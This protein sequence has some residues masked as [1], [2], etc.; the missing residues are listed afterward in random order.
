M[1][2]KCLTLFCLVDGQST[3][4]AFSVKI[5][6]TDS[7]DDLKDLIKVKKTVDFNDIDADKLSIW[8]VSIPD[9]DDERAILVDNVPE[10]KRK[11]LKATTKLSRVF[12]TELPEDTIHILVHRPPLAQQ[13]TPAQEQ[14]PTVKFTITINGIV[15]KTVEWTTTA[16]TASLDHLR[17]VIY[18][19]HPALRDRSH[20]LVYEVPGCLPGYLLSDSALQAHIGVSVRDGVKQLVM[21]FEDPPKPF[22]DI[23]Y[24]DPFRL[25]GTYVPAF[26]QP[27][28]DSGS[29]PLTSEKHMQAL[30][31]LYI[32]LE[33]AIA[34]MP[35]GDRDISASQYY[36]NAFLMHAV[37]LFP[38]L[39][40]K[41]GMKLAGRRAWGELDYG[42]ESEVDSSRILA[43]T[44]FTGPDDDTGVARNIVQ[45][46][47]ISSNRKRKR[48]NDDDVDD[49]APVVSYG[50]ATNSRDWFLQQCSID[51][52]QEIGYNFPTIQSSRIP[53][54]LNLASEEEK[55]KAD[56]KE[57]FRHVVSH[58]H[59]MVSDIPDQ[60]KRLKTE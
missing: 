30:D 14:D 45:L 57:I 5:P 7:V 19:K 37:A 9:D 58:L 6:L 53:T 44:T 47:T 1:N 8:R 56:A 51:K 31:N 43:V 29:I 34:S 13:S 40:M 20:N 55:W 25:Y 23:T 24:Q 54:S 38:R 42:V 36:T 12:D 60:H 50:I 17:K 16:K 33:A 2:N 27:F 35:P 26:S 18:N 28:D 21:R 10:S 48:N 52:L 32:T 59:K 4:N 41:P 15:P 22:S 3:S 49:T 11:K 39:K 46:D